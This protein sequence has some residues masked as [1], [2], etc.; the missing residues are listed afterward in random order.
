MATNRQFRICVKCNSIVSRR[1]TPIGQR[2]VPELDGNYGTTTVETRGLP[3]RDLWLLPLISLATLLV[4]VIVAEAAARIAW[5]EQKTNSCTKPDSALG[6][7]F[8]P[9][10]TS[11]MKSAEGPWYTNDYNDCGYRSAQPCTPVPAGTRRIAL[12]GSSLAE[13]YLVPYP[14]TIGARLAQDLTRRCGAPVEVQNLGGMGYFSARRPMLRLEEALTLR[15]NAVIL[16]LTPFDLETG[17]MEE[18]EDLTPAGPVVNHLG[19][20][21]RLF[22]HLKE[23]RAFMMAQHFRFRDMAVYLPLYL[24]YGDKADYLRP[25]FTPPWQERLRRLDERLGQ[26]SE[27]A[28]AAAVPLVIAFVPQEAELVLMTQQAPPPGV[29][30]DALPEA[31]AAIA[32]RHD[33]GFVDTSDV[34]KTQANPELLYYQVDGHLSGDGQPLAA[35]SIARWFGAGLFS[36]CQ[37]DHS[38]APEATP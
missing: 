2:G 28:H 12:I 29:H 26:L 4:L 34:L 6:Y 16:V 35:Q 9:D 30:P 25:P 7:R 22:I 13:G 33:V 32:A 11:R 21:G 5:P 15:P 20:R 23:S 24:N 37:A 1:S 17:I 31:I 3:K 38:S 19:V 18:E 8:M 27:R 14:D 10:C 36:T